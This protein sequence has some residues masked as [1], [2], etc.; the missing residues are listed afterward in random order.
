[1]FFSLYRIF[2]FMLLTAR[3]RT[4]VYMYCGFLVQR[5]K[6]AIANYRLQGVPEKMAQSFV[7][8]R[9][10]LAT[11]RHSVRRFSAK[12]SERNCLHAKGLCLNAAIKY[13]FLFC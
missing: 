4:T 2:R 5:M 12:C 10:N 1:M 6:E 8:R 13:Y 7:I 3:F 9:Y 11:V